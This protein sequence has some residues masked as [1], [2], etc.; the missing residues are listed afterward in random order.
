[1]NN[2]MKLFRYAG[3]SMVAVGM[4]FIANAPDT[5]AGEASDMLSAFNFNTGR[6]LIIAP[7]G[8]APS[9]EWS[10]KFKADFGGNVT[11]SAPI[12][13]S[14][15]P[16]TGSE[17]ALPKGFKSDNAYLL[18]VTPALSATADQTRSSILALRQIDGSE[19]VD[20]SMQLGASFQI[21][22]ADRA[23]V[24]A[25]TAPTPVDVWIQPS[26]GSEWRRLAD[27]EHLWKF[28]FFLRSAINQNCETI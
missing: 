10:I 13:I 8:V 2:P 22:E 28:G 16:V 23:Q 21:A 20:I 27:I 15:V 5:Q 19:K 12:S 3:I 1:M 4:A 11:G 26:A 24:C 25:E 17:T 14:Y 18:T 9:H 6:V 7:E